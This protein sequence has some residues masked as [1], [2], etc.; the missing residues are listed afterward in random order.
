M[1]RISEEMLMN[2]NKDIKESKLPIEKYKVPM[3]AN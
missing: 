1:L 2:A 3:S